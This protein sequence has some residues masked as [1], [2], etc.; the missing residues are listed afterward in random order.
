MID[1]TAHRWT[2]W[3][4]QS[5]SLKWNKTYWG[6]SIRDMWSCWYVMRDNSKYCCYFTKYNNKVWKLFAVVQIRAVNTTT[7][8]NVLKHHSQKT[9]I[10]QC[11][12]FIERIN[13]I[14]LIFRYPLSKILCNGKK[15][16]NCDQ[17]E[18][19]FSFMNNWYL[20]FIFGNNQ[21]T[22]YNK[23]M[24]ENVAELKK[25]GVQMEMI[26]LL[27]QLKLDL[28]GQWYNMKIH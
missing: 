25:T 18:G 7:R 16:R 13:P 9:A 12:N 5:S 8:V 26:L 15:P 17:L 6:E 27:A 4:L 11:R 10:I 2:V 24:V 1:K 23:G 19:V 20:W 3:I 28:G 22:F 21:N 14:V